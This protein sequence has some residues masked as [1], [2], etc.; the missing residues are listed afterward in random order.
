M[1]RNIRENGDAW[2][3]NVN[4]IVYT[5][6]SYN[7]KREEARKVGVANFLIKANVP[8]ADLVHKVEKI[9]KTHS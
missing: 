1:L 6:L 5:N 9:L 7:E 3:E 8:L 2:G 4:V